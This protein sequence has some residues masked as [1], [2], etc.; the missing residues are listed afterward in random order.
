[1]QRLPFQIHPHNI[2]IPHPHVFLCALPHSP[3]SHLPDPP[4]WS[5]SLPSPL[6]DSTEALSL[7]LS[8]GSPTLPRPQPQPQPHSSRSHHLACTSSLSHHLFSRNSPAANCNQSSTRIAAIIS[9]VH[10]AVTPLPRQSL[11]QQSTHRISPPYASQTRCCGDYLIPGP[12]HAPST[13]R[14]ISCAAIPP[15]LAGRLSESGLGL[16]Y[17]SGAPTNLP[18]MGTSVRVRLGWFLNGAHVCMMFPEHMG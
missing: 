7:S 1:M 5:L 13:N 16:C 8:L 15:S 2:P 12:I 14:C 11:P 17:L 9:P 18:H 10:S 3:F 4:L 6:P